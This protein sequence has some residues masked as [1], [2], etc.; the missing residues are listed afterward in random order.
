[1][2]ERA[3]FLHGDVLDL[4]PRQDFA[5][6]EL[7][8]C[9][10]MGHD[11]WPRENCVATLRKLREAFPAAKRFLLGDA[12]RTAYPSDT[13]LP[14]FTLGFELGHDL[15]DTFLPRIDDWQSV[16]EEGGWTLLRTNRIEKAVG[17]V[18]FELG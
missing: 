15:M 13:E 8:T 14:V 7:L 1:M 5:D 6:V 11:F 4:S 12:T 2:A 3:S 18:I 9:F 10:R 16:F 17:E